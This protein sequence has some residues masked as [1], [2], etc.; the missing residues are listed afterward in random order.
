MAVEQNQNHSTGPKTP[1]GKARCRLN[2]YRHGFTGQLNVV[3]PEEQQAYD[4]HSKII[5]EALVPA[6]DFERD[7]AQSIADDRW[8]LKRARAIEAST[9]AMGARNHPDPTGHPAADEA[10]SQARTWAEQAHN[11]QLL[12]IY[13]QRIQRAVDKNLAQLKAVQIERKE[14]AAEAMKQAKMLYELAQAQGKPYKPEAYFVAAPQVKES[15][16][17]TPE[18]A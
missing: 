1:E 13:E 12:T 16:F 15:V 7:L 5:L 8:R 3:T 2:A 18:I 9:F 17:S 11:L 6:N 4:K 14:A 10:F